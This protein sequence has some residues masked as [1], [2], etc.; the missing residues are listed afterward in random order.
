MVDSIYHVS[1]STIGT[2]G[3]H[4][5]EKYMAIP[6]KNNYIS[7]YKEK[8]FVNIDLGSAVSKLRPYEY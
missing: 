7:Q 4:V 6:T 2:F 3:C 1:E 5:N 8:Y